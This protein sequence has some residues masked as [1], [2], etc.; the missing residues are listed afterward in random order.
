VNANPKEATRQATE[1]V[2][3]LQ[4][5]LP[6]L[7]DRLYIIAKDERDQR[8][9]KNRTTEA[10]AMERGRKHTEFMKHLTPIITLT[11][12][13]QVQNHFGTNE[14]EAIS[15]ALRSLMIERVFNYLSE[16]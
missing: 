1:T 9:R 10:A 11:T 2:I 13:D 4:K 14:Y 6:K 7:K 15:N 12:S 16:E 5:D 3:S 8:N